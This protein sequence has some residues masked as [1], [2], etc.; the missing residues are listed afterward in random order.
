MSAFIF[1]LPF[2]IILS[3]GES[4]MGIQDNIADMMRAI[5]ESRGKSMA[6]FSEELEISPSTLQ[7]YLKGAG[8]PTIKMVQ[9][10][11]E[12]MGVDPLALMAG[13]VEPEQ[14]Q[15]TLLMLDTIQAVSVLPQP[16]RLR[17]AE[18]FLEL[19]QLWEEDVA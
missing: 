8:N 7:E 2:C 13:R 15:L 14:Y 1:E 19:V 12:K 9:R 4:H 16:K 6:D 11:A 5:K 18:L 17:F 10:L 3:K